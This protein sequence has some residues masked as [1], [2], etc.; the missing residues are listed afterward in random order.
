M[1]DN[2]PLE[3]Q[4][5]WFDFCKEFENQKTWTTSC[6]VKIK[7]NKDCSTCKVKPCRREQ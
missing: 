2:Q 5:N 4:I 7:C 3:G 1:L 6:G